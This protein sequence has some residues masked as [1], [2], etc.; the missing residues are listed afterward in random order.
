MIKTIDSSNIPTSEENSFFVSTDKSLLDID[1]ITDFL[2]NKSY[3]AKGRNREIVERSI[4]HSMCFGVYT[5]KGQ[6]AGFARVVTDYAVF[7]WIMDVFV[8][9]EYRKNGLGKLL[10]KNLMEHPELKS[11][12]KWGLKT[13]DAHLL[14]KKFGFRNTTQSELIMEKIGA[15]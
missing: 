10:L 3:W 11:I 5:E 9:P 8:V 12:E 1:L 7:G 15:L 6:Q 14:Y 4:A 13:L 2:R